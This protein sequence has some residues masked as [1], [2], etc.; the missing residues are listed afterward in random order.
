[1]EHTMDLPAA[2]EYLG[3]LMVV[4]IGRPVSN[5]LGSCCLECG[6]DLLHGIAEILTV[7]YSISQTKDSNGLALQVNAC[8]FES[9]SVL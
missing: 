1:M 6:V 4:A 9:T 7:S 3:A 5:H 8:N 2:R